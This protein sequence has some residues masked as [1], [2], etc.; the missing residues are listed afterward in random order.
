[1]NN[2]TWSHPTQLVFGLDTH[3]QVGDYAKSLGRKLLLHY[4]QNSIKKSGLYDTVINALNEAEIEF[5]ELGGVQA[6]PRY[7]LVVEG[8]ELCRQQK[9]DGILAVGGGSVMDSAKAIAAGVF[10]EDD[11]WNYFMHRSDVKKA[12]PI[13]IVSTLP[14]TGSET[15]KSSVIINTQLQHKRSIQSSK[16]L[17][18]FAIIDPTLHITLPSYVSACGISDIMSHLIE[19]YF[20]HTQYVD[21][22]DRLLEA[23]MQSL[24][25]NGPLILKN[26]QDLNA[27][28]EIAFAAALAHNGLLGSGRQEEWASHRIEHELGNYYDTAHGAG[29]AIIIPAWMRYVYKENPARFEQFARRVFKI[30]YAF[31]RQEETILAGIDAFENFLKSLYLPTRLSEAGILDD[32]Y[33]E[34]ATNCL[35]NR[36]G[37]IGFSKKLFKEDII[38]IYQ[39]AK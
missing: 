14:A 11:F 39:L 15:S 36:N 32:R 29:L 22:T 38:A 35:V 2:F 24:I 34:M 37:S 9:V 16:L 19:R 17:P 12:L 7:D 33:E 18:K 23:T 4:G 5:I 26:G 6:N 30:D 10:V 21:L 8:I 3:Q 31:D 1:M 20:S 28:S 27:R 25:V 13:G